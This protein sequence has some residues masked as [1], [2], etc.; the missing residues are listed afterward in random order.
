MLAYLCNGSIT[1]SSAQEGNVSGLIVG[2]LLEIGIEGG[3]ESSAGKVCLGVVLETFT[4]EL[5]LKV[6]ESESIVQDTD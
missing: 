1:K 5:V 2:D 3:V 4:V 6:L